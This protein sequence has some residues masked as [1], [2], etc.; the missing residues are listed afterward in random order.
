[1][2]LVLGSVDPT[3]VLPL[4]Q[5]AQPGGRAFNDAGL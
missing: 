3:E 1:M 2:D 5:Q 4:M